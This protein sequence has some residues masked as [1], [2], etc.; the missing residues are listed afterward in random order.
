MNLK[1]M[2][3]GYAR[4]GKDTVADMLAEDFGLTTMSSSLF[5]AKRVM[6][7]YFEKVGI[8]YASFDACYADRVNHRQVWYEQI[9]AY[10]TPD[11]TRLGRALLSEYDIYTGIRNVDEFQALR[12]EGLFNYSIWVDRSKHLAP[13]PTTSNNMT[14]AMA[15]YIL[16]NN[17][18]LEQLRMKA[19]N[20]YLD[21]VSLEFAGA[22]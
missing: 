13:E 21:L 19:R 20:L 9:K 18:T 7:P 3:F 12:N 11:G 14:P 4:H 10:N 15:N 22:L 8:S 1:L 2:V 6:I 5:A 16:D 17:G